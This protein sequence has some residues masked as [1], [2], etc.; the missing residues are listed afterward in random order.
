MWLFPFVTQSVFPYLLFPC[1]AYRSLQKLWNRDWRLNI[2][3]AT[4]CVIFSSCKSSLFEHQSTQGAYPFP[5]VNFF[6]F[7]PVLSIIYHNT[8][9]SFCNIAKRFHWARLYHIR[10]SFDRKQTSLSEAARRGNYGKRYQTGYAKSPG[11]QR[12]FHQRPER[13][14]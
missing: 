12:F 5:L 4:S 2:M 10:D 1:F 13:G 6:T 3:P 7:P 11:Q 9:N 14:K 8:D